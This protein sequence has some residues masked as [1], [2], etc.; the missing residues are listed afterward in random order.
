[1]SLLGTLITKSDYK[2]P[3]SP[4]EFTFQ[5]LQLERKA[6]LLQAAK[7]HPSKN[8]KTPPTNRVLAAYGRQELELGGRRAVNR[9]MD[10]GCGCET[11]QESQMPC[12]LVEPDIFWSRSQCV[13]CVEGKILCSL[14]KSNTK[15]KSLGK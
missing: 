8:G 6:I 15:R 3:P 12:I 10:E 5:T 11:C 4:P 1:M 9:K 2:P 7:D 14:D 13:L